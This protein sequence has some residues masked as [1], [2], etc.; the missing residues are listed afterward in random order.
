MTTDKPETPTKANVPEN[1]TGGDPAGDLS[2]QVFANPQDFLNTLNK[3]LHAYEGATGSGSMSQ[4]NLIDF[5]KDTIYDSHMRAAAGVAADHYPELV[6]MTKV[7]MRDS[8]LNTDAAQRLLNYSKG[9]SGWDIAESEVFAGLGVLGGASLV[10]ASEVA[11]AISGE[12]TPPALAFHGLAAASAGMGA[13]SAYTMV[14]A[15]GIIQNEAAN[16]PKILAGWKEIN[17]H[18]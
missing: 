15:P 11:A 7:P 8:G 4:Q 3:D 18:A 12:I 6:D 14:E 10:A 13:Y 16:D 9:T 1:T 17:G 5:S 2:R